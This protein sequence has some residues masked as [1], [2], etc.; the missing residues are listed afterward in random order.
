ML[1]EL[2]GSDHCP[3]SISID[4]SPR[5][6]MKFK[7]R[8]KLYNS[9]TN[10]EMF[11]QRLEIGVALLVDSLQND[12]ESDI[13]VLYASFTALIESLLRECSGSDGGSTNYAKGK[14]KASFKNDLIKSKAYKSGHPKSSSPWWDEKC[15][16][17]IKDRRYEAYK[18]FREKGNRENLNAY[19]RE[20][21]R[22]KLEL[23]KREK[24]D[25]FIEDL[26]KDTNP[27]FV[28]KKIKAFQK[29]SNDS[30]NCYNKNSNEAICNLI[31]SL[32]PPWVVPAPR[33]LP[34]NGR[35]DVMDLPFV[36]EEIDAVL[37]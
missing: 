20:V 16:N 34:T 21:A 2:W 27:S 7:K 10:W 6:N 30:P 24:F 9:K 36:N 15:D 26:R 31:E 32:Y 29:S 14:G 8:K 18:K 23:K 33:P 37:I 1:E 11:R 22:V 13:Q 17:L 3:I 4:T 19:V 12:R 25:K 28:W 35:D 5:C